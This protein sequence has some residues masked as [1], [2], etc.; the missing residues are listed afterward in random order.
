MIIHVSTRPIHLCLHYHIAIAYS[1]QNCYEW[2]LRDRSNRLTQTKTCLA[3]VFCTIDTLMSPAETTA[4]ELWV[5]A[6]V[7][8]YTVPAACFIVF[9]FCLSVIHCVCGIVLLFV[10][11]SFIYPSQ[12]IYVL[13]Q[14]VT[15]IACVDNMYSMHASSLNKSVLYLQC[16]SVLHWTVYAYLSYIIVLVD[17]V[18]LCAYCLACK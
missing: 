4:A 5:N 6:I 8:N 11:F 7:V 2:S 15:L 18:R 17:H 9:Y 3:E 12:C 13:L 14:I 1:S 10:C 16:S